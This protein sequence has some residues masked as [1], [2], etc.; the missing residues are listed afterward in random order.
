M[1]EVED[2]VR[3]RIARAGDHLCTPFQCPNCQSQNLRGRSLVAGDA[4]DEA[5]EAVAMRVTLDA[6]WAHASKTVA[7]HVSETRFMARYAEAL[8]VNPFPPLGPYALGQHLGMLEAMM[9]VMRS[10]EK[11]RKTTTVQFGTARKARG[12]LT[13]LQEASP[14]SGDDLVLSAAA[15]SG[16]LVATRAPA[17]GRWY[18]FFTAGIRARMGDV[19]SQDRAYSSEV[20]HA[21][22]GMYEKEWEELH[23]SMSQE[24]MNAVMFL[25]V[26]FRGHE[27]I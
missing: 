15:L 5:F 4:Q 6:F 26:L 24:S 18:Q 25:L 14:R 16:R 10:M 27:G 3:F 8:G 21:L 9:V 22:L 1:A 12:T 17:E 7:G 23:W 19:V 11:G 13:M 2:E 20:L